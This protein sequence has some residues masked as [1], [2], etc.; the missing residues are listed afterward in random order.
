MRATLTITC[1]HLLAI[2]DILEH[3]EATKGGKKCV[4]TGNNIQYDI[5]DKKIVQ[6]LN[7]ASTF[8]YSAL[9]YRR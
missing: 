4:R 7:R 1:I 3:M 9:G 8:V 5:I 2:F 6:F